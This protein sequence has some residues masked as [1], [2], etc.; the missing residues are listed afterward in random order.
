MRAIRFL[1]A[2][3]FS[4]GLLVFMGWEKPFGQPLPPIGNFFSPFSGFWQN[5]AHSDEFSLDQAAFEALDG[6]VTVVFDDR[7]VPHIFAGNARDAVFAQ[8]YVTAYYRLWQMDFATRAAAG[9]LSEVVGERALERDLGQRR[10][11]MLMAAQKALAAWE[12]S[13]EEMELLNAYTAGVNAY[14]GTLAPADYPLE[15]KLLDYAPEAWTPL[16]SALM[17]K[18]MAETLCFGN[19]DLQSTNALQLLGREMF[20]FLYPEHNPRQSPVIPAGTPWDFA[21]LPARPETPAPTMIGELLN[22]PLLPQ[23]PPG[24]GSN[25]WAVSGQ[26][27]TS[28]HP[29]LCNDPHLTLSLPSIW[30]EIQLHTPEYQAYGVSIPGIPGITIG[31]NNELAWGVT[32]VGQDVLDW[33]RIT[34]LDDEKT[35]YLLDDEAQEVQIVEE[36]VEVRGRHAPHVEKVKHTVWGPIVYED[37]QS[38]YRDLAMHW[39]AAD[40]QETKDFYELGAFFRLGQAKTYDD[41]ADALKRY[42]SPAQNFVMANRAGDI[43]L[44]VNGK[45][46]IK[47]DQQG[48][49]VQDGSTTLNEWNGFI[50]MDQIPQV[51]NPA[52]GYVSSANQHSAD[53]TYPYYFLGNFDDYRGRIINRTLEQKNGFTVKDMMALQNDNRSIL[54]EEA[55]PLLT[56][57]LDSSGLSPA[58]RRYLQWL[59]NWDFRF[60]AGAKAPMVFVEWLRQT[61]RLAFDE[62]YSLADSVPLPYPENWRL[63]ELL[64]QSPQHA[65]F[66]RKDTP[67]T[68]TA[69][70]IVTAAL[71]AVTEKWE[72]VFEKEDYNWATHKGTDIN[73]LARIPAFSRLDLPVGGYGEAPNAIRETTGPS[74]RVIVELGREV[75]AYG[76]YPGGQSGHP[77]SRF[78]DNRIEPWMKGEYDELFVMKNPDDRRAPV[79]FSVTFSQSK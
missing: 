10:K 61:H 54:A 63:L 73:H 25:N 8:G 48:R 59:A 28:G 23:S 16:R 36:I 72:A 43:A 65:I 27:T 76:I 77:G 19:A 60:E 34:W 52:R 42:E 74:W 44:R 78:Y 50:P 62:I 1:L 53:T 39:I 55:L 2:L 46:P 14:I 22:Y 33:Y 37:P 18:N 67:E 79:L 47:T 30:F 12:K 26:K 15:F 31:F 70:E 7:L 68:E 64:E 45:F 32:N 57:L 21:P 41:Y 38:P 49:F 20:D 66:D 75:R 35:R 9:R 24:I 58:E 13:P 71:H 17:F 6:P 69:R 29:I 51:R 40:V 4:I 3:A 11:G 5:T 56:A